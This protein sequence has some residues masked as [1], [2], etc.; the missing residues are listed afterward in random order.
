MYYAVGAI[1][2]R[3]RSVCPLDGYVAGQTYDDVKLARTD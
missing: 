1:C 2:N 3:T